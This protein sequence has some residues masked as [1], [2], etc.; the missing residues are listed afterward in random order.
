MHISPPNTTEMKRDMYKEEQV[1]GSISWPASL[2]EK[3]MSRKDPR[4]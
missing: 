2:K 4:V 1:H 3:W